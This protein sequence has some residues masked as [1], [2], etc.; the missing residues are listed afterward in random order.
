MPPPQTML[1][2]LENVFG[3]GDDYTNKDLILTF[4]PY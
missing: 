4:S 1:S 3:S 2:E